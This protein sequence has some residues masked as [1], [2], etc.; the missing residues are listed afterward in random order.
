MTGFS[1]ALFAPVVRLS[2]AISRQGLSSFLSAECERLG[3]EDRVLSVGGEGLVD[4][5]LSRARQ[6]EGFSWTRLDV[7]PRTR[8]DVVGDISSWRRDDGFDVIFLSE[9]LEHVRRPRAAISNLFA[10]L[11]PGGRLI[12]TVPFL[13]PIHHA[14]DDFFRF[15]RFGLEELLADFETVSIGERTSWAET[16]AVLLARSIKPYNRA[17]KLLSP[18]AVL[19]AAAL[20][21]VC[22]VAGRLLPS[23]FMT[24]GY[25]VIAIKSS[26]SS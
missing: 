2:K 21:P 17:L 9:V 11:T 1:A 25:N 26:S 8:P 23:R 12:L 6:A 10:S 5:L 3:A 7:E 13:F 16:Y 18:L 4:D 20:Y 15:T 19:L 24:S 22:W 14:S